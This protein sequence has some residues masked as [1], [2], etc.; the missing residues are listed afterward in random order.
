MQ[1]PQGTP[2]DLPESPLDFAQRNQ[3]PFNDI[4][5]VSR[6]LTHRS[7][8]N[9]NTDAV[10]DNERLEFLGDAVLDFLVAAWLYNRFPE[11]KEGVLTSYRSALVGAPQ[12]AAFGRQWDVGR[13]MRLGRG[14]D[15]GGGR[16]RE[17]L[18]CSTFEAIIGALYLDAGLETVRSVIHPM[19]APAMDQIVI[20]RNDQ[21]PKS[22]LQ[23]WSQ[24]HGLGIPH[25]RQVSVSGPDHDRIF[26]F[27]VTINGKIYGHGTGSSKHIASKDAARNALIG[28]GLD[29]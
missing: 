26:E 19:L 21:D 16:K 4:S 14:E 1:P 10:E 13:A 25:Y 27:E 3:L 5:Y 29:E 7:Y 11:M 20:Q 2:S 18:L 28:L 24:S 17:R 6:A 8:M 12:L 9:E 23:E 15:E 22:R